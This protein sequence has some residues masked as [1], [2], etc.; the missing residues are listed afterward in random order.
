MYVFLRVH[1]DT[2]TYPDGAPGVAFKTNLPQHLSAQQDADDEGILPRRGRGGGGEP[3]PD[4]YDG[5]VR[6]V[7][8]RVY[9]YTHSWAQCSAA[10]IMTA[11]TIAT[12]VNKN[13]LDTLSTLEASKEGEGLRTNSLPA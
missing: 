11:K 8:A 7:M 3:G 12:A 4:D 13:S 10:I 5:H 1:K 6:G 9:V 2:L